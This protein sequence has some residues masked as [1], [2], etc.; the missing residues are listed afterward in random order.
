[1]IKNARKINSG[2]AL[3]EILFYI[4]IFTVLSI[5]IIN[6]MITMA[7][8]FRETTIQAELI[9]SGT[10]LERISREIRNAS[11]INS[12]SATDLKLNIKNDAGADKTVEF[13][14]L[15]NDLRFLENDVFIGNL[16]TPNIAVTALS[17]TQITTAQN[18]AVKVLL[19]IK[20]NHDLSN[21]NENFYDTVV[22]RGNY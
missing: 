13:V 7:K 9:Q 3:I 10:I 21:R 1:M 12:I 5:A 17:F 16:N 2:Y 4:L 19:T 20:S 8:S 11:A 15:G 14:L 18:N 22:L 6:A